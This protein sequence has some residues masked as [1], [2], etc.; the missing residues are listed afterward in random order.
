MRN[1]HLPKILA[2]KNH[3]ENQSN[4]TRNIKNVNF[5]PKDVQEIHHHINFRKSIMNSEVFY[6]KAVLKNFLRKH[7]CWSLL[8][9]KMQAY[10][11][12]NLLKRHSNTSV[13][14]IVIP[15]FLR[16]AIFKNICE[17]LLL[18]VFPSVLVWTFSYMNK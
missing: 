17:R 9:I 10:R 14:L 5:V 6:K 4:G 2:W 1:L 8:L 3:G 15:K 13:F 7:L 16:K 18:R 12:A 11:P